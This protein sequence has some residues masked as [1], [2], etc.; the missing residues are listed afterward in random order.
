VRRNKKPTISL[1]EVKARF[2]EWRKAQ[3]EGEGGDTGR[4]NTF[5]TICDLPNAT[6]CYAWS[7]KDRKEQQG[8]LMGSGLKISAKTDSCQVSASPTPFTGNC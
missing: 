3:P 7:P 6:C 4:A 5:G 1:E 2:E 8:P